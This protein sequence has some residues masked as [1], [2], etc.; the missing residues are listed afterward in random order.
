MKIKTRQNY[1]FL[2]TNDAIA[3]NYLKNSAGPFDLKTLALFQ[4]Y[5]CILIKNIIKVEPN[6]FK[7]KL[8][9]ITSAQVAITKFRKILKVFQM[10]TIFNKLF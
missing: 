10:Y 2:K 5:D 7:I 1:N 8:I 6:A 4:K 3:K 9:L